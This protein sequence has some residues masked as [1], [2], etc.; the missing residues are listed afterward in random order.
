NSGAV[1]R[2]CPKLH[3]A[4]TGVRPTG[5]LIAYLYDTNALGMGRLVTHAPITWLA[6]TSVLNVDLPVTAYN[7]PAGHRLPLGVASVDPLYPR[8]RQNGAKVPFDRSARLDVSL[9]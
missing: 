1:I 4:I 5:T 7:I 9:R 6:S 2:G 8:A 3:L